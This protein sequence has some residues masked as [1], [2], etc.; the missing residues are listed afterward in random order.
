MFFNITC[1]K[2]TK[3]T[4][5][6]D[7]FVF[8]RFFAEYSNHIYQMETKSWI[9][10]QG[11]NQTVG[12][13]IVASLLL[14]IN[15]SQSDKQSNPPRFRGVHFGVE[16]PQ[17]LL[18]RWAER[19]QQLQGGYILGAP[20]G[21]DNSPNLKEGVKRNEGLV[22]TPLIECKHETPINFLETIWVINDMRV[23]SQS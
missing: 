9:K 5:F 10:N 16:V 12:K 6:S 8:C 15:V 1:F 23:D 14:F 20:L 18:C 19:Y 11:L 13:W 2:L 3:T 21:D 22:F 17:S 4:H 7:I